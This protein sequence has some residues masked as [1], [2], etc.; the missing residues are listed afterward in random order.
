MAHELLPSDDLIDL[1]VDDFEL[2]NLCVCDIYVSR[3]ATQCKACTAAHFNTLPTNIRVCD[4]CASR[5][6]T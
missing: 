5:P 4:V 1:P 6:A 2:T 3:T